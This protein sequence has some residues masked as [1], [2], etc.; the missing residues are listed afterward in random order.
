MYKKDTPDGA[1]EC[2]LSITL[3]KQGKYISHLAILLRLTAEVCCWIGYRNNLTTGIR[4]TLSTNARCTEFD[5]V[6][7]SHLV[8]RTIY[9]DRHLVASPAGQPD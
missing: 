4:Q 6:K 9:N 2:H 3:I 5:D 7:P 1:L 8:S